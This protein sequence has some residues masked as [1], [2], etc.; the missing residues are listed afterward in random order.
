VLSI[1]VIGSIVYAIS[2]KRRGL[3]VTPSPA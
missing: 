1:I 2:P 3:G